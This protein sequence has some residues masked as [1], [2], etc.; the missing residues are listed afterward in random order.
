M[1]V[2]SSIIS[3]LMHLLGRLP[4]GF[5]YG[6]GR[7][8]AWLAGSVLRYRHDVVMINLARSFPNKSY[9][10]YKRT[11]QA[12]YRHFGNLFAETMFFNG[13]RNPERLREQHLVEC[14]NPEVLAHLYEVSPS[15][16]ILS[17]HCGNWELTAGMGSYNY[18]DVDWHMTEENVVVVHRKV[19]NK[20]MD[21][22]FKASRVTPLKQGLNAE[23]YIESMEILRYILTHKNEKKFYYFI[24]DQFPYNDNLMDIGEFM[25]QPTVTMSAAAGIAHKLKFSVV[26]MNVRP[27]GKGHNTMTFTPICEDASQMEIKDIM[28]KYYDLLQK[29]IEEMPEH[30]LWTH[31]RWKQTKAVEQL[32]GI[33]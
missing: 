24:T 11:E 26:Y 32:W 14:P 33:K 5:H 18:T 31:R 7:V 2:V 4:F 20:V 1:K 30:Y 3:G 13:C 25:H 19:D 12:F 15:V 23:G 29:D 9:S 8:V 16:V 28:R 27:A 22:V 10:W 21:E 6:F 17:S